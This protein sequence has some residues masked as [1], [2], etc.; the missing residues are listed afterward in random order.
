MRCELED[1][2]FHVMYPLRYRVLADEVRK[3]RGNRKEIV[4]QI[5]DSIQHRMEQEGLAADIQG[6][7]KNLYRLYKKMM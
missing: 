6:R 7:E 5:T 2:G 3:A 4:V 1:L